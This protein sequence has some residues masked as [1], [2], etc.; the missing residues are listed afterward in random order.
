MSMEEAEFSITEND[1]QYKYLTF[2]CG[3]EQYGV[4]IKFVTEIVGIQ[5]IT[6][7]PDLPVYVKGIINLRGS[8]IP[9]I[10]VR[11]LLGKPQ[12]DYDDRTCIIVVFAD[13]MPIG[14]I[15]DSVS[16][17]YNIPDGNIV[18]NPYEHSDLNK[19]LVES[20]GRLG[21]DVILIINCQTIINTARLSIEL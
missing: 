14:L 16:E 10:D 13:D 8:I 17:V 9:V 3:Q 5:A 2:S 19:R 7:M 6:D 12:R 4:N 11:L 15:V 20:V 18:P 21:S 1:A